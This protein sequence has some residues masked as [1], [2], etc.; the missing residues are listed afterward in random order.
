MARSNKV[1][2][3]GE[4]A[5]RF[6]I[7]DPKEDAWL[8]VL[9]GSVR[10]GKTWATL[11]KIVQLCEYPVQGLKLITGVSKAAIYQNVL[12]DLLDIA[13]ERNYS[14]NRQSGALSLFGS[15]WMVVGAKDEGSEKYIRGA[16]V[17]VAVCDELV[18]MPKSFFMMLLSR[19]SPTG[20]RLY[21]TTNPDNPNH[22]LKVDVLENANYSRG[23]GKDLWTQTWTMDDNPHLSENAR[24]RFR[25]SHVGVF[26][27]RF[28]LGKWVMAQGAIYRDV[29]HEH[30]WY[31]DE[32]RPD[33][34]TYPG[35]NQRWIAIDV[36]TVNAFAVLDAYRVDNSLWIENEFYWDS[37]R[38]DRQKTN[39]EYAEDVARLIGPGDARLRPSIV[40]D[41]SAASFRTELMSRGY[42]VVPAKNDVLEGI[43]K[44][45]T[46]FF[47]GRLKIHKRCVN[48][49]REHENYSWSEKKADNGSEQPI[50]Q[51]DHSCDALRYL[52]STVM[53]DWQIAN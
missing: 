42:H 5:A 47:R 31:G 19:M 32:D 50:K 35:R 39:A 29:L 24:E 7:R 13:G 37:R 21:A 25:R 22:W 28:I 23:L 26:Y 49:R 3:F 11:P 48:T 52:V 8:N 15:E 17:G 6:A 34:L 1:R 10:S 41:P 51:A 9:V 14:Y 46:M 44:V 18:L 43:R 2:P 20:A 27:D 45:S 16:T 30:T 12:K 53:T 4:R 40:I 38:T 33:G 36:G